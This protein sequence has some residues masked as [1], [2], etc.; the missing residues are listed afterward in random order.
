MIWESRTS[1]A[2]SLAITLVGA[3][4]FYLFRAKVKLIYGRAN[5]SLNNITVPNEEDPEKHSSTEI[6]IEK[7]F[8][9]NTGKKPAT[10]VEFVLSSFPTD[11]SVFQ[12][13]NEKY[14]RVAKGNCLISIP[15]MAPKELVVIDC[16]YINQKAA[17]VTSVKCAECLGTEV[18]F[19]TV[20]KLPNW[21]FWGLWC[22]L[23][24]G[25]AF[26]VK[27]CLSLILS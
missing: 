14:L 17:W 16:A 6:Y 13:R 18:P 23:I 27:F 4:L 5:N 20:R 19:W 10:N 8:L 1:T 3:L 11:I 24:F 2:P 21:V 7:Y 26:V 15:Q 12:P 9:Q 22:L 25:I